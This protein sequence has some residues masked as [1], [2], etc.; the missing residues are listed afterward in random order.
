MPERGGPPARFFRSAA[1]FRRWLDRNHA[2][3]AVMWVGFYNQRSGKKGIAFA[4]AVDEALCVGW[5][6]FRAR[7]EAWAFFQAQ[8]PGY[9]H[10]S[11]WWIVS[12]KKDET[13]RRRLETLID[14]SARG[15]PIP[16]LDRGA[17][18]GGR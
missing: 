15:R 3:A 16:G 7:P 2:T 11:T 6:D 5:I 13:R 4:E 10:L 14:C 18:A 9:R 1:E 8:P 12:A 17:G